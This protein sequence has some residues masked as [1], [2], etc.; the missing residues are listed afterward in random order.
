[1]SLCVQ[2]ENIYEL[3]ATSKVK[4]VIMLKSISTIQCI[5]C[6]IVLHV[7]YFNIYAYKILNFV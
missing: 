5:D 3:F 1:M 4:S 7:Q 2:R 6:D